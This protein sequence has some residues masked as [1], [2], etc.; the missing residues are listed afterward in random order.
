MPGEAWHERE[1]VAIDCDVHYHSSGDTPEN[2]TDR[3]P[4]NT[5]WCARVAMLGALR[6]LE[7][8]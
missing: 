6:W 8:L 3:E 5:A 1:K 4:W 2:T 7:E